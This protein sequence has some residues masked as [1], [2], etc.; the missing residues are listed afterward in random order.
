MSQHK[1]TLEGFRTLSVLAVFLAGIQAQTLSITITFNNNNSLSFKFVNAF[2]FSGIIVDVFGAILAAL[3]SRWFE[4]L[5]E[6]ERTFL[7]SSWDT[8]TKEKGLPSLPFTDRIQNDIIAFSLFSPMGVVAAG[9]SLY[10]AGLIIYVWA[11]QPLLVSIV[12]TV[13]FVV[14]LFLTGLCFIPHAAKKKLI[15]QTLGRKRGA[16]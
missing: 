14:L 12:S 7:M 11:A 9:V 1:Q 13:A 10:L 4:L 16:W 8:D 6:D 5:N 2:W 3:T 15:I